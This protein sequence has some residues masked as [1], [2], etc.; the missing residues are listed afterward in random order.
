MSSQY[1]KSQYFAIS[2]FGYLYLAKWYQIVTHGKTM[3][4]N[5]KK[6]KKEKEN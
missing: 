6:K 1:E 3:Q 5:V 2:T 4:L